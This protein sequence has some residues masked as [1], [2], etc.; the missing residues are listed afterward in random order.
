[1]RVRV[2][3]RPHAGDGGG[4]LRTPPLMGNKP[5]PQMVIYWL[6]YTRT[7][8]PNIMFLLGTPTSGRPGPTRTRGLETD[9]AYIAS[10]GQGPP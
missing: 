8:L 4:T 3:A 5:C 1:M 10:L 9:P 2:R 6:Y 7:M